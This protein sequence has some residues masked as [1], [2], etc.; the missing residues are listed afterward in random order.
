[1]N[2]AVDP[3][4]QHNCENKDNFIQCL[5]PCVV[6]GCQCPEGQVVNELTNECVEQAMC[7]PSKYLCVY[8]YGIVLMYNN[9]THTSSS[10]Y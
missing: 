4:C 3:R 6:N 7:P 8:M 1:M 10:Y 5:L 2:C 9:Y